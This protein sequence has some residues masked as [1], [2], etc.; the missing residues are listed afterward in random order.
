MYTTRNPL[1]LTLNMKCS[2]V[3]CHTS[4][5]ICS[6]YECVLKMEPMLDEVFCL[7]FFCQIFHLINATVLCKK[8]PD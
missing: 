5:L 7:L 2:E 6:D 8:A 1:T 4:L 3:I